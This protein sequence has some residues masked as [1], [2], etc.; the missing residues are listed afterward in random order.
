[1][2]NPVQLSFFDDID[3][4]NPSHSGPYGQSELGTFKDNLKA[5]IHNWFQYPAG[6][7]YKFVE[8][9]FDKF[10]IRTGDWVYDP[11]SGTGT[12]L[13][14]ARQQGIN[15]YGVEA[16]SFVH[17]VAEVKLCLDYDFPSLYQ[18]IESL[19]TRSARFVKNRLE[20]TQLEDV[21]PALIYKCYHTEDLRV[22]YLLR[23]FL[24]SEA[25]EE[26]LRDFLK[27]ALTSTLR[28]AAAAGTGW[29][30]VSPRK[31]TGD[32]PAKNAL[33]I[34]QR[35]VRKMYA[36]LQTVDRSVSNASSICNMLGDSRQRQPLEDGQISIAITSP[37]YLNNYDYA[38]RTRL[39]TYFWGIAKSWKEITENFRDK[40][41]VA[42]TTQITRNR[43]DVETALNPEIRQLSPDLYQTIQTSVME[44]AKLRTQKGGKKDYD[45]MTALYFNDMLSVM[46]ETYRV[47]KAGG[48]FCLV[49]GDSAPYGV[50]IPTEELIG[51]L[52][53]GLGFGKVEYNQ[54]RQR[55]GKWKDN[56][57]RHDVPLR[58]GIVILTR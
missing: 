27:L 39:E 28:G 30:Y 2:I 32:K 15:A 38:D 24:T 8:T 34:F 4:Q 29:P 25:I 26:N 11:F 22:L 31:N 1:L 44:L 5:P 36:D 57:Q 53:L 9:T 55:G 33:M 41:M 47:L 40:L 50:H 13:L 35:T 19:L 51:Q 21:F 12:T 45:L 49:L 52:G 43:Y 37:P 56:P 42:A 48:R 23:E 17:W 10:G 7:S 14:C 46:K 6:Y 18:Q 16:H 20:H 3:V 58:E 54:L